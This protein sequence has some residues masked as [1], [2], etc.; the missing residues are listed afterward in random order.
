MDRYVPLP[1]SACIHAL[2][3]PH[4]VIPTLYQQ[5]QRYITHHHSALQVIF[6]WHCT[7]P[8]N[9]YGNGN[10]CSRSPRDVPTW[11]SAGTGLSP[12][13]HPHLQ[14]A[15]CNYMYVCIA[16]GSIRLAGRYPFFLSLSLSLS[17]LRV[18]CRSPSVAVAVASANT[19]QLSGKDGGCRASDGFRVISALG[20]SDKRRERERER[21][22]E[23]MAVRSLVTQRGVDDR[24]KKR[25]KK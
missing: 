16:T 17:Q 9:H 18:V 6:R 14:P 19:T 2:Y 13:C 10:T 24:E 23:R 8:F 7:E 15:K 1:S 21:E 25:K 20:R 4:V 3:L 5:V 22:K 12:E 11:C